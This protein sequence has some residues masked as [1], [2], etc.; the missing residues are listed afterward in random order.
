M[1]CWRLVLLW[2]LRPNIRR[3]LDGTERL[4]GY[5]ARKKPVDLTSKSS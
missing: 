4:V 2:A 5:R 1:A 3:L